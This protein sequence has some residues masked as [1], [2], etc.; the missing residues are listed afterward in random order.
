MLFLS[1]RYLRNYPYIC[2]AGL[3]SRNNAESTTS[4]VAAIVIEIIIAGTEFCVLIPCH[5]VIIVKKL[6]CGLGR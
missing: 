4:C 1:I 6:K 2:S 3:N 5:G